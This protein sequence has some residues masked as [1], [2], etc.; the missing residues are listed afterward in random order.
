M[1]WYIFLHF[2]S[3]LLLCN[4][5]KRIFILQNWKKYVFF[6]EINRRIMTMMILNL[7]RGG[8]NRL[9]IMKLEQSYWRGFS[10]RLHRSLSTWCRC[11]LSICHSVTR[12]AYSN[13]SKS[14]QLG[15]SEMSAGAVPIPTM[16]CS[17][18][19]CVHALLTTYTQPFPV[20]TPQHCVEH[21]LIDRDWAAVVP[22]LHC[23]MPRQPQ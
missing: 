18:G 17:Y 5:I 23:V 7:K 2:L 15:S 6:E 11:N 9:R 21:D 19:M 3:Y 20:Y 22:K 4:I 14:F 1:C 8:N 16:P 12:N 10:W 13:L